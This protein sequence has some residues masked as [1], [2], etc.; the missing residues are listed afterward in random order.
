MCDF[1]IEQAGIEDAAYKYSKA[2]AHPVRYDAGGTDDMDT[3]SR[4]PLVH[5]LQ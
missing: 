2:H 4:P 5:A 1:D 3:H